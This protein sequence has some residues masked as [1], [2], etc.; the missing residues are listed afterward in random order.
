MNALIRT[1]GPRAT[2]AAILLLGLCGGIAA[3]D[4][5]REGSR[6]R[7]LGALDGNG[8]A[9][10]NAQLAT[11]QV[12]TTELSSLGVRVS[13]SPRSTRSSRQR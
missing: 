10:F 3:A 13:A 2:C 5:E 9:A 1:F 12:R 6:L 8:L 7:V 11:G 4:I